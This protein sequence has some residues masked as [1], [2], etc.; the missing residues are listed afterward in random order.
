MVDLYYNESLKKN[1]MKT[2]DQKSST[3]GAKATDKKETATKKETSPKKENK[4]NEKDAN[5]PSTT[6]K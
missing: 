5:K 2:T 6:K 4:T 3:S 1:I